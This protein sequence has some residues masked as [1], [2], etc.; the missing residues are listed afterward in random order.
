MKFQAGFELI[1]VVET[2]L[3][4]NVCF[5]WVTVHLVRW[6]SVAAA[7]QLPRSL[8]EG[9]DSAATAWLR[10]P[11]WYNRD[12]SRVNAPLSGRT[13]AAVRAPERQQTREDQEE[14]RRHQGDDD[15]NDGGASLVRL[16]FR[17]MIFCSSSSSSSSRRRFSSDMKS[18]STSSGFIALVC[19]LQILK[20]VDLCLKTKT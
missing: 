9:S 11:P 10:M 1:H 20:N 14:R 4:V 19:L 13:A 12:L 15:D 6:A 7:L 8:L 17:R 2:K 5:L 18:S 16:S 3:D